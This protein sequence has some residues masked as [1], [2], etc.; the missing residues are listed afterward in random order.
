MAVEVWSDPD[1]I[2]IARYGF[3]CAFHTSTAESYKGIVSRLMSTAQGITQ[4][5]RAHLPILT[6]CVVGEDG[7]W[8]ALAE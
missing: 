3:G 2:S 1:I 4:P 6:G 8:I 5:I 7:E